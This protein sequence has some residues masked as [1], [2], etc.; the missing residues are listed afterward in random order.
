[1]EGLFWRII[2][3]I[4]FDYTK[5]VTRSRNL[6][7]D[8]QRDGQKEKKNKKTKNDEKQIPLRRLTIIQYKPS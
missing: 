7:K 1:M 2:Q 4:K 6:K 8:R 3:E 5:G